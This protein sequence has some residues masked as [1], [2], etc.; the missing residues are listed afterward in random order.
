MCNS[1]IISS[2]FVILSLVINVYGQNDTIVKP[3]RNEIGFNITPFV[4]SALG[5]SQV[6]DY[7]NLPTK[8]F[9]TIGHFERVSLIPS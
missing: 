7:L 6:N 2:L 3:R 5:R 9:I 8:G 4:V 1:K